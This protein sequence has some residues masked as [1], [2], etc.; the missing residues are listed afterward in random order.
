MPGVELSL[1]SE[2]LGMFQF[3]KT[4]GAG[5]S[6]LNRIPELQML[7]PSKGVEFGCAHCRRVRFT[8]EQYPAS[9]TG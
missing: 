2:L 3:Q 4:E 5:T 8:L 6:L 7:P 1:A 9:Q